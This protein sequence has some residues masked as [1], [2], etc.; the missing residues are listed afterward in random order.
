MRCCS[1]AYACWS[2]R[3]VENRFVIH[4]GIYGRSGLGRY[5]LRC[6]PYKS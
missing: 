4:E 3:N 5:W 6:I 2:A 1:R